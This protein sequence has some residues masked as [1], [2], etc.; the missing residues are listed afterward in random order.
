MKKNIGIYTGTFDPIHEGHLAF[1]HETAR[2]C[3]L[4]KIVIIPETSPREK[5]NVTDIETRLSLI[6]RATMVHDH[7]EVAR[8]NTARF[9]VK[10]TLPE[11]EKKF[12]DATFTLLVGSDIIPTFRYRWDGLAE[13]F[14]RTSLA[15]GVREG[16]SIKEMK[17]IITELEEQYALQIRTTFIKTAY[18]AVSSSA[19]RH[20]T[21]R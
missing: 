11:L 18:A 14:A 10:D 4:D 8:L 17:S 21:N 3:H 16:D 1:S 19:I 7:I 15:I 6:Q 20:H 12:T 5:P 9:T 2:L 13:L